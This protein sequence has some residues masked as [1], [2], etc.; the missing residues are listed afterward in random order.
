MVW[1]IVNNVDIETANKVRIQHRSPFI[2]VDGIRGKKPPNIEKSENSEKSKDS[3]KS[4]GSEMSEKPEQQKIKGGWIKAENVPSPRV[5]KTH[6]P[7]EFLPP[8]LLDT[9]KVI[10]VGRNPKDV[11]VSFYHMH[12]NSED[13]ELQDNFNGFADLFLKEATMFGSYWNML[14]VFEF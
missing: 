14:K 4:V 12:N 8:K 7:F 3:E 9:C 13:H 6:L 10:F 1:Q 11:C 5:I 2:E